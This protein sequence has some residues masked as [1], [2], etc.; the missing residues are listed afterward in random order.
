[1]KN[2]TTK[3]STKKNIKKSEINDYNTYLFHQGNNYESY[4]IMGSHIR[5]LNRKKGVQFATWAPDAKAVYVVGDFNNFEIIEKYKLEKV[6]DNGIWKGFFS[7]IK[8][9][10]KYKYCIVDSQGN[11]GEYKSDPYSIKN[12]LRPNN[13]SIVYTPKSFR[14]SDTKWLKNRNSKNVLEEP[15]NIYEIHLGSWKRKENGDFLS[16]EE[17][18]E[19]LPEYLKK[20]N[21]T[22]VEFMPIMEHPLDESWGYQITGFF[23]QQVDLVI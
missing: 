5:T 8:V 15:L 1:M 2:K 11:A 23:L 16:Y 17:M 6:T 20:M 3:K 7:E 19:E 14:W 18:S 13:A 4:D 9:G 22:H 10:S 21:Y 12:E